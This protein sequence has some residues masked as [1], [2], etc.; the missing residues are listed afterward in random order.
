V[1]IVAGIFSAAHW[2]TTP[3]WFIA[4]LFLVIRPVA[5]YVGLIGSE[6][7]GTQ[8]KLMAWFG[9]RGIGSIYYVM[10]AID[11]GV[12]NE[13]ASQLIAISMTTIAISVVLHGISVTPL[14][15]WYEK[16]SGRMSPVFHKQ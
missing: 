5:V 1:L 7:G 12:P 2:Q 15:S 3:L 14:M 10:Y 13:I 9:I 6:V 11:R 4:L 8:R 16:R